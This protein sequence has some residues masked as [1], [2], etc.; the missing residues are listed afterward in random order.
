[1]DS[2]VQVDVLIIDGSPDGWMA[3]YVLQILYKIPVGQVLMVGQDDSWDRDGK[4]EAWSEFLEG[5]PPYHRDRADKLHEKIP[6]TARTFVC[7]TNSLPLWH[8]WQYRPE[9][10]ATSR[11]YVGG[12]ASIRSALRTTTHKSLFTMINQGYRQFAIFEACDVFGPQLLV[13]HESAPS[14]FQEAERRT[15]PALEWCRS[16][17]RQWNDLTLTSRVLPILGILGWTLDT[18]SFHRDTLH[19]FALH[20]LDEDPDTAQFA[21]AAKT[22]LRI[23]RDPEQWIFD[24]AACVLSALDPSGYQPGTLAWSRSGSMV[25]QPN[26]TG[27]AYFYQG[28]G[29]DTF[30][31]FIQRL[32]PP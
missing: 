24:G 14:W 6:E 26:T 7:L 32:T 19:K 5:P 1:M 3:L 10:C 28:S 16:Q 8:L 4:W 30:Q 17:C 21:R 25:F 23:L 20:T 9:Q 31:A 11:V 29:T 22:A 2:I 15:S 18:L 12:S 27:Q 13:D